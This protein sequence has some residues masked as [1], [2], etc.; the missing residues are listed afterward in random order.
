[1]TNYRP[2]H[3]R[4]VINNVIIRWHIKSQKL[5]LTSIRLRFIKQ[6]VVV[7]EKHALSHVNV[8]SVCCS[9]LLLGSSVLHSW[10]KPLVNM[11]GWS[12][13]N[14]TLK[15]RIETNEN[16][17]KLIN[18]CWR[19]RVCLSNTFYGLWNQVLLSLTW[20]LRK[21]QCFTMVCLVTVFNLFQLLSSVFLES[22][23]PVWLFS[24]RLCKPFWDSLLETTQW[25][26]CDPTLQSGLIKHL[27]SP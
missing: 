8:L 25:N 14:A 5:H 23:L 20:S 7:E 26:V 17:Q 9:F 6:S 27:L 13:S 24:L 21:G 3:A 1:M 15:F 2:A 12:G 16:N 22:I 10:G 11:T 19:G 18:C 4:N